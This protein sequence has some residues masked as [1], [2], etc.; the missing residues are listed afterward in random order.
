[1]K[2][3]WGVSIKNGKNCFLKRKWNNVFFTNTTLYSLLR[4]GFFAVKQKG[5][6]PAIW[7]DTCQF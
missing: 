1:M 3:H 5:K 2:N 4:K 7:L 6:C